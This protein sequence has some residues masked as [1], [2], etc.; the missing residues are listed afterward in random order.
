MRTITLFAVAV[1]FVALIG[2]DA[3]LC[4]RTLT[5]GALARSSTFNPL[6]ITSAAKASP[7]S[8]HNDYLLMTD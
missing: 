1:A 8:H 5:T 3:W 2:V 4:N 6:I 7:V